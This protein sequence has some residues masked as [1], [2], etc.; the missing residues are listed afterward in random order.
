MIKRL[1][2]IMCACAVAIF[3]T[4]QESDEQPLRPVISAYTAEVGSSHI[5]DTYLT[6]L[7]YNGIHMGLRYERMQ[8]MSFN[9]Q[10]WVMQLDFQINADGDDNFA[11]N[12]TMWYLDVEARWGMMRRWRPIEAVPKLTLGIGPS[13]GLDLGALYLSRNGNNPVSAKAAWTV[14]ASGYAAYDLHIG[15]LPITLRYEATLPV[16]GAFF[17]PDYGELYY[18]IWL[19]NRSKLAHAA[20]WGNYFRLDN[21]V[22]ADLHF[23]GTNLRIGYHNDILSTKVAGIVSQRITHS[24]SIG[25]TTEWLTLSSHRKSG[26][27]TKTIS[28]LY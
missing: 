8:A 24:I 6:P 13:T 20:W 15:K 14:N 17:S 21:Y 4:A 18:E 1:V 19:G 26:N 7:K 12:A 3:A 2:N 23:G 22:T 25:V 11:G 28:A 16:T 5:A 10:N 27:N 9:P